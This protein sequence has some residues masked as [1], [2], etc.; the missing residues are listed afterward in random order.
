[1]PDLRARFIEGANGNLGADIA[2]GLPN[3]KGTYGTQS[4][5]TIVNAKGA[6]TMSGT[7]THDVGSSSNNG[8]RK[9]EFLASNGEIKLDGTYQND[10]YGKSDTVQ[11]PALAVNFIIKA[12]R[13]KENLDEIIDDTKQD[14]GH[15]WSAAKILEYIGGHVLGYDT[16]IK[17]W[18][19]GHTSAATAIT[20][21]RDGILTMAFYTSGFFR[22]YENGTNVALAESRVTDVFTHPIKKGN[23]YYYTGATEVYANYFYPF[24]MRQ[25]V[26]PERYGT[27]YVE[28][29]VDT[30]KTWIDG[31]PI[32]RSI[33]A[34]NTTGNRITVDVSTLNIDLLIKQDSYIK[35]GDGMF[36]LT[37]N[38]SGIVQI[39]SYLSADKRT[40]LWTSGQNF[41]VYYI[42]I[43]YTKTTD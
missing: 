20:A 39:Q 21:T 15:A 2:A 34:I 22:F 29:E 33:F 36:F 13:T 41:L 30:G 16:P 17:D 1:M 35:N 24:K 18:I 37:S 31:K 19:K 28:G 5:Y 25:D 10:V 8:G 9:M 40:L 12:T 38:V 23:T 27:H 14:N 43:E 11:P 3:I 42:Y 32:Y 4:Y 6:F 26:T 7:N